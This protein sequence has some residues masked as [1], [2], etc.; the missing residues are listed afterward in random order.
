[1]KSLCLGVIVT[2]I[3]LSGCMSTAQSKA[4]IGVGALGVA[5]G[6]TMTVL[7]AADGDAGLAI[8]GSTVS[9]LSSGAFFAGLGSLGPNQRLDTI[10]RA[11]RVLEAQNTQTS[12]PQTLVASGIC[13]TDFGRLDQRA[14]NLLLRERR[15]SIH[16]TADP[17]RMVVSED[18]CPDGYEHLRDANFSWQVCYNPSLMPENEPCAAEE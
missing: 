3:A 1:M 7:S 12:P 11:G 16:S 13:W 2:G 8:A 14:Q 15:E 10:E 6:A 18:V 9:F 4:G 17:Y 5:V